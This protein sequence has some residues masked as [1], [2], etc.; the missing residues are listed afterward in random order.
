[1]GVYRGYGITALSGPSG[2]ADQ[3]RLLEG[4]EDGAHAGHIFGLLAGLG[5]EVAEA[6]HTLPLCS[7][8]ALVQV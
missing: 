6:R 7:G 5:V 2:L 8:V 4:D 1:M 3:R